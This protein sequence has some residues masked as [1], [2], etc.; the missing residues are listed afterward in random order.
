MLVNQCP[1]DQ[2]RVVER[3]DPFL[4]R[5][6][7]P[8]RDLSIQLAQFLWRLGQGLNRPDQALFSTC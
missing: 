4:K 5:L 7:D 8:R 6:D 1:A 2:A 3:R